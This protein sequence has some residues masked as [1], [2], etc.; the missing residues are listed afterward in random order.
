MHLFFLVLLAACRPTATSPE[1][2][3]DDTADSGAASFSDDPLFDL[4][5]L[6]Q[7]ELRLKQTP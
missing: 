5:R 4:S 7:V 2:P 3:G 6:L 1:P